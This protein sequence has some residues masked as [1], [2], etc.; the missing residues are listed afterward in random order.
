MEISVSGIHF[1][2]EDDTKTIL[3]QK[4][5][6]ALKAF[7]GPVTS[8]KVNIAFDA[9]EYE[10][11]AVINFKT[12]NTITANARNKNLR[13]VIDE[14]EDKIASQTRKLKDKIS[15][16]HKRTHQAPEE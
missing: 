9:S 13:I 4:L 5:S 3:I 1:E 10:G 11:T 15:D 6:A 2:L 14:L 7:P 8:A 12:H 16:H